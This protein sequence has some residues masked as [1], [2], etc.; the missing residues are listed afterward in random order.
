MIL[1]DVPSSKTCYIVTGQ[2]C[3]LV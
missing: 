1:I 3:R 2:P